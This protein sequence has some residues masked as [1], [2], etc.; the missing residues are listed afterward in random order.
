MHLRQFVATLT[1]F[2]YEREREMQNVTCQQQLVIN[3]TFCELK[4]LIDLKSEAAIELVIEFSCR[5]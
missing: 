3:Y 1:N 2:N 5:L 4:Y